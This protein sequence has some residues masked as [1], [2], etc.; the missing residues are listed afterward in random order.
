MIKS[1]CKPAVPGSVLYDSKKERWPLEGAV[2][3]ELSLTVEMI[4][5]E[6]LLCLASILSF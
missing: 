4:P 5:S 1:Y 6:A 2:L 3:R